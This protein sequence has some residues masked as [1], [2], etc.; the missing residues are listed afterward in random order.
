MHRQSSI[1]HTLAT[2]PEIRVRPF[3]PG[4]EIA[5]RE[6]NE[7]WIAKYF[8]IEEAERP[9]LE[10]P[11]GKILAIGGHIFLAVAGE[12]PVG[13]CALIP[14]Q[15][16]EFELAKMAV[17]ESLRGRGIGRKILDYTIVQAKNIGATRLYL[18]TNR[19]LANAIHL[20]ESVG[21]QHVAPELV[22]P[23]PYAR[24]NVFMELSL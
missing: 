21:F 23:S 18:E 17:Q 22:I 10:D 4:D 9:Y 15:P 8:T 7:A 11:V 24:A 5:F 6:L 19:K 2:L 13:C 1:R 20:Y 3:Q 14:T 12:D 16:G